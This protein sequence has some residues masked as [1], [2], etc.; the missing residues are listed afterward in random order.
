M[1][2]IFV[3]FS[4]C[5]ALG[6]VVAGLMLL[7]L[8]FGGQFNLIDSLLLSG[9]PLAQLSLILLPETFWSELTGLADAAQNRALQSF[10][11]LCAGLGQ[12]GLLLA[13]GFFRLWYWR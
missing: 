10:L 1:M 7:G 11:S 3:Q 6:L 8:M 2:R 9:K 12:V 5:L 4:A 13:G